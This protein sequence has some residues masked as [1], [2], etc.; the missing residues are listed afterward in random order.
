MFYLKRNLP[1]LERG[2]RLLLGFCVAAIS[3]FASPSLMWTILGISTA[4]TLV[5]TAMFGFCP[6]CAMLGR[7]PIVKA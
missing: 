7:K 4:F 3:A 1:T 6:A 5:G 2:I